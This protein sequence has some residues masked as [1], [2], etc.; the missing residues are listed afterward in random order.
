MGG[1]IFIQRGDRSKAIETMAHV[2]KLLHKSK[3]LDTC[4]Y[5]T[6]S[7]LAVTMDVSGRNTIT[8]N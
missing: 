7:N 5:H 3:V 6:N 8:S 4:K 1:N 2:A